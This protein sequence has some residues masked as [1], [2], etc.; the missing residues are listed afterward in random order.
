MFFKSMKSILIIVLMCGF[1]F[2]GCE[3]ET[4]TMNEAP[5]TPSDPNPVANASDVSTMTILSWS[6]TDPDGD[7]LSYDVYFGTSSSPSLVS[8][9]QTATSYD[10][11]ELSNSTTYY[12][13]IIAKDD[14]SNG[15]E[16][17]VWSFTAI[18]NHAPNVPEN[19]TPAHEATEVSVLTTISWSCT[20]P[21]GDVLTYD[22]YFGTNATL[23][24]EELV[25]TGQSETTLN[26]SDLEYNTTY[27][28]RINAIDDLSNEIE[29][30]VWS[31][32]TRGPALGDQR[33][34]DLGDSGET[35]E[36]IWLPAGTFLMGAQDD[37]SD[38]QTDERPRHEVTISEGFW[39]GKYEVTQAQ[40]EAVA[41]FQYFEWPDNPNYPAENITYFEIM[42]CFLSVLGDEWRLPTEAEWEYTARNGEDDEWF[43]WGSNYDSI[44]DYC[45]YVLNSDAQTHE[46][47]SKLP[48]P[49]GFY[50]LYGN[51]N[52]WCSD[53]YL[54]EYYETSPD[55]DP[56]GPETGTLR[57]HRGGGWNYID[58]CARSANRYF[59]GPF[60]RSND[61]GFR[62]VRTAQ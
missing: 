41:G 57:V 2:A 17:P 51:V 4:E 53:W 35:I 40:W 11:G 8:N 59:L 14:F 54:R 45:W 32:S 55:T 20:D 34:F 27:F 12:W 21:D 48:S 36:M 16:G 31:F 18:E 7:D 9:D 1:V 58:A 3:D 24:A 15:T 47:G 56:Q 19:P 38:A 60:E 50:D 13:K 44:D 5:F 33:T 29:G 22:V 52:E 26:L 30:Q 62:L 46:V 42:T 6:C 49:W 25:S 61:M 37:E 43:W 10:P 23:G 39:M 28:W